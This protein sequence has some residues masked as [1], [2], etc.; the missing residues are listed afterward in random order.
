MRVFIVIKIQLSRWRE[1]EK[2]REKDCSAILA[3]HAENKSSCFDT[4]WPHVAP[5]E[6]ARLINSDSL[7]KRT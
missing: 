3:M 1:T 5:R 6:L 2:E 4:I 7:S